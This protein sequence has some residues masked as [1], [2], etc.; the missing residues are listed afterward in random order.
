M[1]GATMPFDPVTAGGPVKHEVRTGFR[2]EAP[3]R[4]AI[5]RRTYQ[6]GQGD[7]WEALT[8]A[9]RIPRWFLPVTGDLR[10]GG[11]FQLTGNAG[12]TPAAEG[13]GDG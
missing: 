13:A 11:R 6:A 2:E 10:L 8:S 3:T 5:A 7:L 12:D 9:D 1:E 4:T